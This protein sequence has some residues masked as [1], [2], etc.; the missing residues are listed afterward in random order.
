[1]ATIDDIKQGLQ[2]NIN[3]AIASQDWGDIDKKNKIWPEMEIDEGEGETPNTD[4]NKVIDKTP[5]K[6]TH[7]NKNSTPTQ[8]KKHQIK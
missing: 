6:K 4:N 8:N 1:M 3:F 2:E 5:L 7:S